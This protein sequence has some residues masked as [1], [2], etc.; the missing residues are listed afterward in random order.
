[1][2]LIMMRY[3]LTLSFLFTTLIAFA[4]QPDSIVFVN[5][6]YI[7]GEIKS[8][9]KGVVT[10]E[11]DYSDSDFKIE[12][13]GIKYLK[14]KSLLLLSTT[15]GRRFYGTL[16]TTGEN[17]I[18]INTVEDGSVEVTLNE[19]V[20]LKSVDRGF[21]DRLYVGLDLG[22]S[23]TK[24]RNQRQFT[25]RSRAGYLAEKWMLD[26]A[27][28]SLSSKQ[29][30]VEDINRTDGFF[31]FRYIL[32]REWYVIAQIDFLSNTEQQLDLRSNT[33]LGIGKYLL[34]TNTYYWGFSGG[35]SFN[36]EDYFIDAD[37]R[38]STEGWFGSELNLY[39]IGDF[40]LYTKAFAYPS[41]TE[42][43]RWRFDLNV[44]L[45]YDLPLDFYIKSG[46]TLN[47]D[48]RPVESTSE[49]DYVW[50]TTFGWEL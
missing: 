34:R 16:E 28:N 36:N 11:T 33:K 29:D 46:I 40:S 50:Q 45:Q 18:R 37:D 17:T 4:Q 39:D 22:F 42:S 38:Q 47:Y 1:M 13:E 19:I 2:K 24:A 31:S 25:V 8:L 35:V 20:Y 21:F 43:G 6:N 12:W 14:T 26:A 44:D 30:D 41:I 5:G 48:N 32:P 27:W 10:V 23:L 9:D 49:T 7:V 3:I 15:D